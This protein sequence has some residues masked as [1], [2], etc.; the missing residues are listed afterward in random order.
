ME[1]IVTH[2]T[3]ISIYNFI[4]PVIFHKVG[5]CPHVIAQMKILR[6]LSSPGRL[7]SKKSSVRYARSRWLRGRGEQ[8]REGE[9]LSGGAFAAPILDLSEKIHCHK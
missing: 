7:A 3:H 2:C 9:G 4:F 5:Y 6:I 8:Q 1:I